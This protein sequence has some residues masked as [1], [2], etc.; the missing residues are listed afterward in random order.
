MAATRVVAGMHSAAKPSSD[1]TSTPFLAARCT[2]WLLLG[3]PGERT[4]RSHSSNTEKASSPR[5]VLVLSR[6]NCASST[7]SSSF[8]RPGLASTPT[9]CAPRSSASFAAAFPDTPS[10]TTAIRFP[11]KSATRGVPS[12]CARIDKR[13]FAESTTV[14]PRLGPFDT[15]VQDLLR[16]HAHVVLRFLAF[17]PP[18]RTASTRLTRI[19]MLRRDVLD[20]DP[21][22]AAEDGFHVLFP[23]VQATA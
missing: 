23:A 22:D 6:P 8:G 2:C 13:I 9:T 12:A 14:Q 11:F 4:I 3:T 20:A 17:S 15:F 21:S 16:L 10:P 18:C 7:S 5:T 19:P 1:T